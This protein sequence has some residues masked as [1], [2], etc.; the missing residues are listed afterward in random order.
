M[1][2]NYE[3]QIIICEAYDLLHGQDNGIGDGITL[4]HNQS[5]QI[6]I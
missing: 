5:F 6:I 2:H 4:D 3:S 1:T